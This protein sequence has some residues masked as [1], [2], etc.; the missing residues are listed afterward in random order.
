MS[1]SVV[2]FTQARINRNYLGD[3]TVDTDINTVS[4][5]LWT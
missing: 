1:L 4:P 2:F 5:I 3:E